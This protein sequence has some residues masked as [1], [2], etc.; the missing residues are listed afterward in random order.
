MNPTFNPSTHIDVA[1]SHFSEFTELDK[2]PDNELVGTE[3]LSNARS[4]IDLLT[5]FVSLYKSTTETETHLVELKALFDDIVSDSR[6]SIAN[7]CV[8][9]RML[10]NGHESSQS[11]CSPLTLLAIHMLGVTKC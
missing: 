8:I 5:A 1:N 3:G 4:L 7:C 11:T 9:W 10:R 2:K 6:R